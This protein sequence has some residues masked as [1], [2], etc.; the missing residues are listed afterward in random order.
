VKIRIKR[1]YEP[2]TRNDGQRILV[3]RLWPRGIKKESMPIWIRDVAPSHALRKWYQ[4][5]PGKWPEFL[6]R[7]HAELDANPDAVRALQ[8]E[9]TGKTVTFLF[10]TKEPELN[11]A[12]ALRR[13]LER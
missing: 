3:D 10:S 4:H 8:R 9:M 5:E 2:P 13:Y 7:Y 6:R 1:V 12:E 11:N